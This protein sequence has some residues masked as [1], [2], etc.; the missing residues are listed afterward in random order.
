LNSDG[1]GTVY[2]QGQTFAV[3]SADVTLYA[4]WATLSTY[5]VIYN[6]N[7][8]TGGSVPTDSTNYLPGTNVTVL[9]NTGNL[10]RSGYSFTGW[11]FN[12]DG[13]GTVYTQGQTFAVGSADVTLYAKWT[14][15][16]TYS[17]RATGPAGGLIFYDKGSYS[18][19]PSWRYLE[20][21]P[22]STEWGSNVW[23]GY[24]TSVTGADG[25]AIG[26]GNQNTIDIVTQFGDS[27]PYEGK[28]DYAAKLCSDLVYGGYSDWFLPSKNELNLMYTNLKAAG[29]GGFADI[30]YWSS[31][32][33]YAYH[34]W[35]QYFN[36]GSQASN[37]K[38]IYK[39]VR[40]V[41]AF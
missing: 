1:S 19:T 23:G 30:Y 10:V 33:D 26:T 17:I 11:T 14:T 34:A 12:S 36:Y 3:G 27:E 24:G 35:T 20:A 5:T 38:N 8:N 2:T 4:K 15:L 9:G 7:G 16:P 29:V 21:A 31:S 25:T 39:R 13:S 22:A 32:E 18:G 37:Y 28:T 6:G 41:R 40:A